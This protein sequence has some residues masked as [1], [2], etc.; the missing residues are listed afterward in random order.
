M[1]EEKKSGLM[2][3]LLE[4]QC[5]AETVEKASKN[6]FHKYKYASAEDVLTEARDVLASAGL[7]VFQSGWTMIHEPRPMLTVKYEIHHPA[8][9]ESSSFETQ[10]PVIEDKGRPLDKGLFGA[11]TEGLAYFLRGLL[12]IPRADAETPSARDDRA[13]EPAKPSKP[14][15]KPAPAKPGKPLTADQIAAREFA[16]SVIE[17]YP[18]DTAEADIGRAITSAVAGCGFGT[19]SWRELKK[20]QLAA[21]LDSLKAKFVKPAPEETLP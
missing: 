17:L 10:V 12:L 11:L 20:D 8:S 5:K 6:E 16:K 14:A 19:A 1:A 15:G 18:P 9:A 2:V 4:A 21:V 7:V 13:H 3:A